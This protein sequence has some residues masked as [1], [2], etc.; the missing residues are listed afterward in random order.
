MRTVLLCWCILA[1][2]TS[3]T[4]LVSLYDKKKVEKDKADSAELE[5]RCRQS[6][7]ELNMLQEGISDDRTLRA[8]SALSVIRIFMLFVSVLEILTY[9]AMGQYIGIQG[10]HYVFLAITMIKIVLWIFTF[11]G[12][13][14]QTDGFRNMFNMKQ[15][16]M[17][18]KKARRISNIAYHTFGILLL[19]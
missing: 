13:W 12:Q 6:V 3:A 8:S 4:K 18:E 19:L 5:E 2:I 16:S 1:V 9:M 17:T 14:I 7:R 15:A 10:E 11:A